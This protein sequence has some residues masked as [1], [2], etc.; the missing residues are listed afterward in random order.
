MCVTVF[1]V[2]ALKLDPCT[3]QSRPCT[4]L[5]RFTQ[6]LKPETADLSAPQHIT[7]SPCCSQDSVSPIN[8]LSPD[9]L[10]SP[11]V[12]HA[13]AQARNS[14]LCVTAADENGLSSLTSSSLDTVDSVAW[15]PLKMLLVA[16]GGQCGWKKARNN[17]AAVALL[18]Q[19]PALL[20]QSSPNTKC[21]LSAAT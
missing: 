16:K 17:S 14:L 7:S 13:H 1:S 4:F 12:K 15:M 18:P 8:N 10:H 6:Q 20:C 2:H 11:T 9:S 19:S 21:H 5:T 3:C